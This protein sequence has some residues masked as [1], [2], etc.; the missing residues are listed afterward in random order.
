MGYVLSNKGD[1]PGALTYSQQALG[2]DTKV[3][4]SDRPIVASDLKN[5]KQIL[6]EE[7]QKITELM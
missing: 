2:I 4:G 7:S 6:Q 1:L 3:F 5:I